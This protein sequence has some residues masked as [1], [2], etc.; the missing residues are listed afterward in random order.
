MK[1]C[2]YCAEP[3]QNAAIRCKHCRSNLERAPSGAPAPRSSVAPRAAHG[4][5]LLALGVLGTAALAL[6]GPAVARS[7]LQQLRAGRCEPT[8]VV[9]WHAAMH[10]GCL[11]PSYVCEH[12][13]TAGMLADPEVARSFQAEASH[14]AEMVSRMRSAFGCAP[15]AGSPLRDAPYSPLVP[16]GSA[17]QDAPL[18]L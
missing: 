13:T 4:P 17:A 2:P 8:N 3:I 10:D 7:G 9:E 14:L 6:A 11:K 1:L 18:A 16:P 12:M 5:R 15:E